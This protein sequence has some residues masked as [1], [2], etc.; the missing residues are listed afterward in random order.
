MDKEFE[1]VYEF[2]N[3]KIVK[4]KE[5]IKEYKTDI[6]QSEALIVGIIIVCI[7]CCG[8]IITVVIQT[9]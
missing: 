2:T 7:I 5:K 9:T 3:E 6:R 4:E 8:T 1:E